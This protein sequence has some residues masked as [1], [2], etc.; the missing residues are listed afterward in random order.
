MISNGFQCVIADINAAFQHTQCVRVT[1]RIFLTKTVPTIHK[2]LQNELFLWKNH[3]ASVLLER[4]GAPKLNFRAQGSGL[5]RLS[6]DVFKLNLCFWLFGNNRN[7]TCVQGNR[8]N[9]FY[10]RSK[11]RRSLRTQ[12]MDIPYRRI[13]FFIKR[14]ELRNRMVL[15]TV[16]RFCYVRRN[17]CQQPRIQLIAIRRHKPGG[18]F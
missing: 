6:D 11:Q 16:K 5:A 17:L 12:K 18:Q 8:F 15:L 10:R 4:S 9:R 13:L 14:Y 2:T 7:F 1:K 3:I